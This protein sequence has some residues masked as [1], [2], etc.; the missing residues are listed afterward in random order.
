MHVLRKVCASCNGAV[1]LVER[2]RVKLGPFCV[3]HGF[4]GGGERGCGRRGARALAHARRGGSR[5]PSP[6]PPALPPSLPL[7]PH[8][9]DWRQVCT[10]F[11]F[12][13]IFVD[14]SRVCY[15]LY[16]CRLRKLFK[17]LLASTVHC[18]H[19]NSLHMSC[20]SHHRSSI[21]SFI[22]FVMRLLEIVYLISKLLYL[23][24][25]MYLW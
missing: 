20:T 8:R 23:N 5:A 12:F 19:I 18:K 1:W 11:V 13:N 17:T 9:V 25:R 2:E 21:H 15:K 16:D 10:R 22:L 3:K 6:P 24:P 7:C 4:V 14:F